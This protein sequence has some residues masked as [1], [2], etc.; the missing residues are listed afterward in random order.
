MAAKGELD[1]RL[2]SLLE[3]H[4]DAIR[5]ALEEAQGDAVREYETFSEALQGCSGGR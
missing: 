5:G 4:Y 2:T 3:T 1:A